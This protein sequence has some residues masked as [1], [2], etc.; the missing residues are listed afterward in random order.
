VYA[1]YWL[2]NSG[3][4]PLGYAPVS[5]HVDPTR[6]AVTAG[7]EVHLRVTV[8]SDVMDEP[9]TGAVTVVPPEGWAASATVLPYELAPAGHAGYDLTVTPPADAPAGRYALAVRLDE[10]GQQYEDLA[11]LTITTTDEPTG[12]PASGPASESTSVRT[13]EP[14]GQP[15]GGLPVTVT[16]PTGRAEPTLEDPRPGDVVQGGESGVT[17]ELAGG[18]VTAAPGRPA[19]LTAVLRNAN[20]TDLHAQV[21]AVS[22]YQTWDMVTP[23]HQG[24]LVPAGGTATVEVTVTPPLDAAPSSTWLLLKAASAG[25]VLYSEAVQ[26]TVEATP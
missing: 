25:A 13:S 11:L 9:R 1:R 22:P 12:E 16:G 3:P 23:R 15:A 8:A 26:L 21:W 7:T 6:T 20:R 24:V 18:A 17:L 2:H 14:A 5:V 19:V 4:A 10:G